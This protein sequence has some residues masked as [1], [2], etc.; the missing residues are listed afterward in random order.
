VP[1]LKRGDHRVAVGV[2]A[3]LLLV[4]SAIPLPRRYTPDFGSFGPDTLLH[5]LGHAWLTAALV[6]AVAA[7][8]HSPG[9][10]DAL[11]VALSAGY[12]LATEW[13]QEAIPGREFEWS[14]VA[15]GFL[16]SILVVLAG[17]RR[18]RGA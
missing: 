17:R 5:L 6:R 8:H 16:G 14:D 3:G 1:T 15:A 2:P 4:G 18:P 12:G 9:R 11:A 7:D 13:L 10:A